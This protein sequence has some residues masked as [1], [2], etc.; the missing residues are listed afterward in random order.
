MDGFAGWGL[1]AK[2]AGEGGI[3]PRSPKARDRDRGHPIVVEDWIGTG[4]IRHSF[5]WLGT[6]RGG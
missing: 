4:A 1:N 2:G 3:P 5:S 6:M